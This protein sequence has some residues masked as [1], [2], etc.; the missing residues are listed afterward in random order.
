MKIKA[1]LSQTV[2]IVNG[3]GVGGSNYA[4]LS[5]SGATANTYTGLYFKDVRV[6]PGKN[7]PSVFG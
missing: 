3:G 5:A 2:N 6:V 1:S 4:I 7:I